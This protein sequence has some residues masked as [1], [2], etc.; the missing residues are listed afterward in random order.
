MT[1]TKKQHKDLLDRTLQDN[2]TYRSLDGVIPCNIIIDG[3][4]YNL[5]IKNLSSAH[6]K[7]ENIWRAQ[8][9]SSD[10][11]IKMK[12]SS[13]P[14]IFLG[15][16]EM[17]DVYA[18]WNPHQVKQRLNEAS[19][20]S[21]YSRLSA[22]KQAHDEDMFIRQELN[23]DGEVLIFPRMRL[24]SYLVNIQDFFPDMSDYVAMGSKR[25]TEANDAYREL[26]NI[27]N[28]ALFAKYLEKDDC[29]DVKHYCRWLKYLIIHNEFSHHRK[30]F[31]AYDT[32]FQYGDA[33]ERFM[34]N[35]DII[36]LNETAGGHIKR[37]L[38]AYVEFL[39]TECGKI[40]E[41]NDSDNVKD[42]AEK[43]PAE[44]WHNQEAG[45]LGT[46]S[47]NETIDCYAI[48]YK[49]GKITRIVDRDILHMIEPYLNTEYKEPI[50]AINYLKEYYSSKFELKMEFKD[51]MK[52]IS[53]IDWATC[54]DPTCYVAKSD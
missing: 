13:I 53:D 16:D 36:K 9:P 7:N 20:V 28:L 37:I 39:K 26:N 3:N 41:A 49:N 38:L 23:N 34:S 22:Q 32:I 19:Y 5:Y 31:L 27:H 35:E 12:E 21:F 46:N 1:L 43:G 52:L 11:F 47:A 42:E 30:D 50:V 10:D 18:T 51:W 40:N 54:Y 25:R 44:G 6:F 8:L 24:S 29:E 17:N 48:Y 4:R 14:F 45:S 33:V 15:Y 2:V